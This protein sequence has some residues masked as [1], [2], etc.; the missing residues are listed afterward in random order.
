MNSTVSSN[1][2]TDQ[3][4][5][6]V[7]L[8]K[9]CAGRI[10]RD[11]AELWRELAVW[12]N[13]APREGAIENAKL[14]LESF[15]QEWDE[16]FVEEDGATPT[17]AAIEAVRLAIVEMERSGSPRGAADGESEEDEDDAIDVAEESFSVERGDPIVDSVVRFIAE[18][19]WILDPAWQRNF[20][21][22][23]R[24]Q[25]ALIESLLLNL[26]I[27]SFLLYK[28]PKTGKH[29]VI[30]G[31]QRL[32]TIWRFTHP[33]EARGEKKIRFRTFSSKQESWKPGQPLNSAANKYYQD[34]PEKFRTAFE[35]RALM[36]FTLVNATRPQLYQIFKRYN[37]GS[38]SLNAAEIRNAVYQ[39]SPLHEMMFRLGG[40]HRDPGRFRDKD[41]EKVAD[42]LRQV[43]QKKK[44]RY[45]AYD[46]IGRFFAFRHERKGTV[47]KATNDFI[48]REENN[49]PDRVEQFR[50]EFIATYNATRELYFPTPFVVPATGQFHAFLAT[51]QMVSTAHIR[52]AIALGKIAEVLVKERVER[53][54]PEFAEFV[55]SK[56]QNSTNFWNFQRDWIKILETD[57]RLGEL[58]PQ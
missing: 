43:M 6:I 41:E 13:L 31:R 47:A 39:T 26:P 3:I 5:E 27:P 28:E 24:K 15:D 40:E 1:A 9:I 49:K 12:R 29:Y 53:R 23:R 38:V 44:E 18:G 42:D 14:V 21:W 7:D 11:A 46:F 2:E 22:K 20:V 50:R 10:P 30:D 48:A 52:E 25:Q 55:I 51:I 34:L 8:T 16:D 54:W 56:K 32:E 37:T 45:G 19:Q 36:V 58:Y 33:K 35:M 57:V 4:A 17:A